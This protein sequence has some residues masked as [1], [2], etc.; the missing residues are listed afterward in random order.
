MCY[1]GLPRYCVYLTGVGDS[2]Q[3]AKPQQE[4]S[5]TLNLLST[6]H[7]QKAG[8]CGLSGVSARRMGPRAGAGAVRSLSQ[9]QVPVLATAAR[10]GP[11]PTVR[12]LVGPFART[13]PPCPALV[14]VTHTPESRWEYGMKHQKRHMCLIFEVLTL[15]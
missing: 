9:G 13:V 14:P 11:A 1:T 4:D 10:A 8:H 3:P 15:H 2:Y 6:Y 12:F 7:P 5:E